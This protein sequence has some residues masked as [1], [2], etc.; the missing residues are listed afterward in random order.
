MYK[1]TGFIMSLAPFGVFGLIV[2]VVA[3]N[4]TN[5][6]IPLIKVI[7]AVYIGCVLQTVFT[8]AIT[9]KGF[10]G[11]SP[12]AFLKGIM[13][14]AATAFST[15]SSSGTLPVSI[16]TIKENFGVSDKIASF[17]LPLGATINMGGTSLY[18]GV[19]ALFIAQVYGIDLSITQMGTIVLTATLGAIGT[20]GVP[21][22][23]LIMLSIVLS[24]VGLPLEGLTLIAGIDRILDMARTT[25][26]VVG[27]LA[28]SIVVGASEGEMEPV[29]TKQIEIA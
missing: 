5:V 28:A 7:G 19:C 13:P 18:Q 24:S 29:S 3:S 15:S 25:V 10:A 8:Y 23:G 14:A 20:A 6:L 4:G 27:D 22:G 9:V 12:V 11:V 26:N 21:G 16:K 2:P 1:I 17:V